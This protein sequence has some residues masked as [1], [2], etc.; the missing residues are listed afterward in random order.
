VFAAL[1]A[2]ID[3]LL[4]LIA[5]AEGGNDSD[6]EKLRIALPEFVTVKMKPILDM[7][8]NVSYSNK[9]KESDVAIS[10]GIEVVAT[11]KSSGQ[12]WSVRKAGSMAVELTGRIKGVKGRYT[13]V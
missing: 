6:V 12:V 4:V 2:D 13:I 10:C 8:Q 3:A 11:G 5:N 1:Q 9:G 7:V